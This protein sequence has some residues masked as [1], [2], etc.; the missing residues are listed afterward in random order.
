MVLLSLL[1][2]DCNSLFSL[3]DML[4]AELVA[5]LHNETIYVR[6]RLCPAP[7]HEQICK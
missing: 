7:I 4:I 2:I 3:G 1:F 6:V 5:Q